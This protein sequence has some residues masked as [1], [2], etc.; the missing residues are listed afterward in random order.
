MTM[1]RVYDK[2]YF[3]EELPWSLDDDNWLYRSESLD[4]LI[5]YCSY[6]QPIIR[7]YVIMRESNEHL[8]FSQNLILRES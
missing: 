7:D 3:D 1:Y 6:D 8:D 4:F 2:D 5:D